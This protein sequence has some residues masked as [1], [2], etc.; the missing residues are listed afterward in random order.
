MKKTKE[1]EPAISWDEYI[2]SVIFHFVNGFFYV[3]YCP[4]RLCFLKGRKPG[5]PANNQFLYGTDINIAKFGLVFCKTFIELHNIDEKSLAAIYTFCKKEPRIFALTTTVGPWDLELEMEVKR[6][7]D[8]ME[9]M[10]RIKRTFPDSIK[11]YDSIVIT[12]QSQINY[13]PLSH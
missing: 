7:E 9:I 2:F 11:G 12:K 13:L 6:V 8:M 3:F 5:I 4:V 10:N 1:S